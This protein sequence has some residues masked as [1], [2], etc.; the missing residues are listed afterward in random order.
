MET[1]I[2]QLSFHMSTMTHANTQSLCRSS[3][4]NRGKT[5]PKH[6]SIC[7]WIFIFQQECIGESFRRLSPPLHT[8]KQ[9][10]AGAVTCPL[11]KSC[12]RGEA[13]KHGSGAEQDATE[14][15]PAVLHPG[16]F[17]N[18]QRQRQRHTGSW[19]DWEISLGLLFQPVSPATSHFRQLTPI[20]RDN[21]IPHALFM[22]G[23][24]VERALWPSVFQ[25]PTPILLTHSPSP[26]DCHLSLC[27]VNVQ[28]AFLSHPS[29]DSVCWL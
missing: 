10:L 6:H 1:A 25:I 3:L 27:W 16:F 7:T 12:G 20:S 11:C 28:P 8:H 15:D 23:G 21:P 5:T 18:R 4:T 2:S 13:D 22:R 29:V 17:H 9:S 14:A 26:S 19:S 24:G